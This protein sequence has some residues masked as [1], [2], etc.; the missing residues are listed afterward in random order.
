MDRQAIRAALTE[1]G[2]DAQ[3]MQRPEKTVLIWNPRTQQ[4]IDPLRLPPNRETA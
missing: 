1:I 2:K 4:G 3:P